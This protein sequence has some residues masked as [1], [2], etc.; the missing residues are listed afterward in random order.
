MD[1]LKKVYTPEEIQE[2]CTMMLGAFGRFRAE[3]RQIMYEAGVHSNPGWSDNGVL[4]AI[5]EL[6]LKKKDGS[7]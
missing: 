7:V 3:L 4:A 2:G 5:R 1:E 6:V